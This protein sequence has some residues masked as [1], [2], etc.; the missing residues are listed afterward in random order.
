MQSAGSYSQIYGTRKGN[1]KGFETLFSQRQLS[2]QLE[3]SD[4]VH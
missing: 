4:K 1:K 2:P 3:F